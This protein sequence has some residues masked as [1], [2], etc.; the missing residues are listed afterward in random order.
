MD[1]VITGIIG[2]EL[3]VAKWFDEDRHIQAAE[4]PFQAL[5]VRAMNP[6]DLEPPE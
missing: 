4:F 5:E 6:E 1:M 2:S 3:C